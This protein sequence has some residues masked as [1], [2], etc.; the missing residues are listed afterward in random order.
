MCKNTSLV[1]LTLEDNSNILAT[2][3]NNVTRKDELKAGRRQDVDVDYY[4]DP[5]SYN[6]DDTSYYDETCDA[7]EDCGR[8]AK[9]SIRTGC[10]L[11]LLMLLSI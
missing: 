4:Y 11:I 10:R 1:L 5:D 8:N 9:C 6:D 2:I 7:D 3:G